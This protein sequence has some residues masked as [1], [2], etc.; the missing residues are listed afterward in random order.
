MFKVFATNVFISKDFENNPSVKFSDSGESVRIRV[1]QKVYDSRADNNARWINHTVKAFGSLSERIKK[2][3]LKE[4]SCVNFSGRLDEDTWNDSATGEVK[5]AAVIVLDEIEYASG[6]GKKD[7]DNGKSSSPKSAAKQDAA[8][9]EGKNPENS[10]NFD[11]YGPF[12]GRDF[13]GD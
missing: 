8:A 13:F 10:D 9:Q 2:M 4:G 3:Q 5:H 11:G 7:S 6:G 12:D 1:S